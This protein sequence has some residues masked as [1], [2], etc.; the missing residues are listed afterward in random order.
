MRRGPRAAHAAGKKL[1]GCLRGPRP[2]NAW[3]DPHPSSRRWWSPRARSSSVSCRQHRRWRKLLP[4]AKSLA[5][6]PGRVAIRSLAWHSLGNKFAPQPCSPCCRMSVPGSCCKNPPFSLHPRN[7]NVRARCPGCVGARARPRRKRI[8]R[9]WSAGRQE[10]TISR[11]V[12]TIWICWQFYLANY[13]KAPAKALLET[14]VRRPVVH[15]AGEILWQA[16][17]VGDFIIVVVRV[18][19]AL[20]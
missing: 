13:F 14:L 8:P 18:F 17:H 6:A 1:H 2:R 19:V 3:T 9:E 4:P 15:A 5:R 16:R 7:R 20:G 12:L 11:M 10:K